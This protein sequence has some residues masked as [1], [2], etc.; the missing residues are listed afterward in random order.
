MEEAYSKADRMTALYVAMGVF[1]CLNHAVAVSVFI[2][3]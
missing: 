3:C 2:I 1:F